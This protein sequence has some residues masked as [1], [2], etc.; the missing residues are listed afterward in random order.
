MNLYNVHWPCVHSIRHLAFKAS[1]AG[2]QTLN[3]HENNS[4]MLTNPDLCI[5]LFHPIY[6]VHQKRAQGS[7]DPVLRIALW[8]P[9]KSREQKG[10]HNTTKKLFLCS[11]SSPPPSLFFLLS[12]SFVLPRRGI[13][14]GWFQ[15][16]KRWG[17]WGK[18]GGWEGAGEERS[19]GSSGKYSGP[20]ITSWLQVEQW[21][22]W[23]HPPSTWQLWKGKVKCENQPCRSTWG[24]HAG[25]SATVYRWQCVHVSVCMYSQWF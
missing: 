15:Q 2:V 16:L 13:L 6:D 1:C 21:K 12:Q 19:K 22:I 10:L 23:L 5:L 8:F 11:F 9:G 18:K 4:R 24:F 20:D 14:S 17:W 3:I 7:T 25:T